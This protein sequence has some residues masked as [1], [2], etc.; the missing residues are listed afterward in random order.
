MGDRKG[1]KSVAI[2]PFITSIGFADA[3]YTNQE[4]I[5]ASAEIAGIA[6]NFDYNAGMININTNLGL[7]SIELDEKNTPKTSA[8]FLQY[9]KDGFYNGIIFHRVIKGFMVQA[10]GFTSGMVNKKSNKPIMNEADQSGKNL[11]GT[12]AMARTSDP[13]S[14]AAQFF[15]N[16]A[17][18]SFLDFKSKTAEGWGYCVFG[19]VVNGMDVVDKIATKPTTIREGHRDVPEEEIIIHEVAIFTPEGV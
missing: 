19:K 15:I 11:R 14:A 17:D 12:L 2:S 6:L 16:L 1:E 4:A 5:S 3:K 8:N 18:N 13:H 10:G 9:V 7:I